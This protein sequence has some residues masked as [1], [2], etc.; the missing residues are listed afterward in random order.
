MK[1]LCQFLIHITLLSDSDVIGDNFENFLLI[2]SLYS[3]LLSDSDVICAIL[4]LFLTL[5]LAN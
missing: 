2:L 4:L 5:T 1:I 3:T